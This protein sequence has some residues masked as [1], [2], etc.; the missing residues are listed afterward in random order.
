MADVIPVWPSIQNILDTLVAS[1]DMGEVEPQIVRYS[2]TINA[3][4]V[5]EIEVP[6]T[7][8]YVAVPYDVAQWDSDAVSPLITASVYGDTRIWTPKGYPMTKSNGTMHVKGYSGARLKVSIVMT[9]G[10]VNPAVIG[11]EFPLLIMSVAF[12]DRVYQPMVRGAFLS[13]QRM[14]TAWREGTV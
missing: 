12:Y 11:I 14:A 5:A 6:V 2:Q 9:N 7:S 8:G 1:S 4:T 10:T 13:L 3:G